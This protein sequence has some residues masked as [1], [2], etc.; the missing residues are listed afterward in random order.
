MKSIILFLLMTIACGNSSQINKFCNDFIDC[1]EDCAIDDEHCHL[2]VKWQR[3]QCVLGKEQEADSDK[4][5]G[6]SFELKSYLSCYLEESFC[7]QGQFKSNNALCEKEI[8]ELN[9]CR[10]EHY[11]SHN[12]SPSDSGR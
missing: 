11:D 3:K 12:E 10:S 2:A 8:A 4:H 5:M 1:V 7:D 6:C 9:T